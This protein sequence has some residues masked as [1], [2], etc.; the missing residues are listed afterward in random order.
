[1]VKNEPKE[2]LEFPSFYEI[3]AYS[4]YVISKE[5]EVIEKSTGKRMVG[6]VIGINGY[7]SFNLTDDYGVRRA[8]GRHRLLG[9]VFKHPGVPIGDLVVN[10][11]NG[12]PGCDNLDNLE[13]TTYQG[14]IEHAGKNGLTTKCLPISVKD[15]IT[16]EIKNYPSIVECARQTGWSKDKIN[17]RVKVGEGRVFPEGKQYRL[18]SVKTPWYVPERI[19]HALLM[20]SRSRVT[21]IRDAFTGEVTE[22]PS[23]S[24]AARCLGVS[25]AAL[26][27]WIGLEGMPILP[28]FIQAKFAHDPR[29]W[30]PISDP[31]LEMEMISGRRVVRTTEEKTGKHTFFQSVVE[32]ANAMGLKPTALHFRLRSKGQTVFK[33]GFRYAYYADVV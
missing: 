26:S 32:C 13:W 23:L 4:K 14:N 19:D 24:E 27:I 30:R 11:I 29:Q 17:W 7:R 33:D 22:Y 15:V 1:M 12:I 28:G 21:L 8:C 9:I 25:K 18:A 2:S 10:H 3:P 16:G 20:N 5:G 31:Y 6:Y